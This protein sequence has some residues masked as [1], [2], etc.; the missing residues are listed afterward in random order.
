VALTTENDEQMG[1]LGPV[2]ERAFSRESPGGTSRI[3][4]LAFFTLALIGASVTILLPQFA[5]WAGVALL[6]AICAAG[7]LLFFVAIPKRIEASEEA[8]RAAN[9]AAASNIA[10]AVTARDGSVLDCNTAYRLLAGAGDGEPPAP[11]QLAFPGERPAA[12]LYRLARAAI[13]G[14]AREEHFESESGQRLTA[15]VRPLKRGEAAWWFTPRLPEAVPPK[16][17][18]TTSE[19]RIPSALIRFHDF[20]RNAPIGVAITSAAGKVSDANQPFADFFG[21]G[22]HA[23]GMRFADLVAP[24]ERAAAVDRI[25][26]A[27]NGEV[28]HDP[29]EIHSASAAASTAQLFASPFMPTAEGETQAILYLVDNSEQK[30]LETQF[31]QS[32]KMQAIGQLAGG[33]AHDFNN[34]LQA[35]MG[36]CDLLLMRHPAGDPSFE[37]INEVRQNSVRAAGLVRQ[38]LAFSRQQTLQPKVLALKDTLT[39]LSML[40]R[41]L[42]GE[43]CE[44]KIDHEPGLWTVRA[45]EGQISNAIMNLAVNARDAMPPEGGTLTIR[46]ANYALSKP[47][48][49]GTGSMPAG[50]Y[51]QIDVKDNGSGNAQENLVK[52]FEPFFTTKPTGQGTGLGLSTVYGI[53][54]QTGGFITVD[55]E[56]G[57]GTTF[58]IYLPRHVVEVGSPADAPAPEQ[59]TTAPADVTGQDTVLLVEDEDAVRSFAARALRMRGYT[60]MEANN[61]DAALDIVRSHQGTIDLLVTDVVMPNMDGPT[62]VRA[63]KRLRPETRIIFMSG[64]AEEAFRKSEDRDENMH[65]LPKPFG[66][67]QLVAKVKEVLSDAPPAKRAAALSET[68]Q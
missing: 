62:L 38:L 10:W 11:P 63:A 14:R 28:G 61:G 45:D 22:A 32:Q 3:A 5:H 16:G 49:I 41:R 31:A 23:Q 47:R 55:S 8:K 30:A 66:L 7:L 25:S 53:V 68:E 18:D 1:S 2:L 52:I 42:L 64:Y 21:L 33:V 57:K 54:K 37:E 50:E 35:I 27:A 4:A 48:P 19:K 44:L 9:A 58:T 67:K 60:V 13:D 56:L 26:R 51:V 12:S 36:N 34:L 6:T 17:A 39:E 15:A 59:D 46:T 40:L 43:R 20:F 65:F 29:V 24:N